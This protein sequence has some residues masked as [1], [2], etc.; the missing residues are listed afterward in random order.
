LDDNQKIIDN[1]HYKLAK[2]VAERFSAFTQVEAVTLGGS[3]TT[4]SVDQVSDI[5]IYVYTKDFIPL[6][7]RKALV[8][9][10]G[11][12]RA[13][14]DL[15]YWDLGDEWYH[16]ETG[17]EVDIIYWPTNWIEDQIERVLTH[18]VASTGYSTCFWNTV[19][20]SVTLFD[21]KNWFHELQ[22]TCQ[23]PYPEEL[24]QAIIIKNHAVLRQIIPSYRHQIEKAVQRKDWISINHRIAALLA[25]YFDVIFALNYELNPGEK[26]VLETAIKQCKLLPKNMH[27]QVIE[28]L[29]AAAQDKGC[30]LTQ[31]D[32]LIDGLEEAMINA[33]LEVKIYG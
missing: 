26:K 24:R 17:I 25:S 19:L 4:E 1:T 29:Q 28:V 2:T 30:I 23:Q 14:L 20:H 18:Y 21:R 12:T 3:V 8:D 7:L 16:A 11:T 10:L 6:Y 22:M 9:D 27:D 13:D 33:G 32:E 31:V 5:D 15:Q